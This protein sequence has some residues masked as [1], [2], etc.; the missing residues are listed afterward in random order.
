MSFESDAT[1]GNITSIDKIKTR[2]PSTTEGDIYLYLLGYTTA[3]WYSCV[4]LFTQ[5]N[6]VYK[7]TPS[8]ESFEEV[9]LI[10]KSDVANLGATKLF[11]SSQEP[12]EL[13]PNDVWFQSL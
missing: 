1:V 11:Y 4:P 3:T 2:F 5:Q 8:T 13:R 9:P 12:S 10:K 6:I 7:Y